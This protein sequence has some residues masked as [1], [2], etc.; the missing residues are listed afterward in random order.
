MQSPIFYVPSNKI[1]G[2]LIELPADESRHA[3]TV[4]RLK[5]NDPVV[6]VDGNGMTYRGE[7]I[8]EKQSKYASVRVTSTIRNSGEPMVR[9]T[10]AAGLS[11]G[12]KFDQVIQQGTEVGISRFVPLKTEKSYIKSSDLSN[13]LNR[14]EKVAVAAM[15]Q[16]RR[17]YLPD[18]AGIR[19]LPEYLKESMDEP[20]KL[21]FHPEIEQSIS[22]ESLRNSSVQRASL[23]IGPESGFSTAEVNQALSAGFKPVSLGTR[24][25]R[26]ETAGPVCAALVLQALG[27]YT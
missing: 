27:E 17:S 22:L 3:I 14:F 7:L 6:V 23:L 26:T 12:F 2:D 19:T 15:K 13:K 4:L 11:T 9:L 1:S 20:L 10:L 16:S 5:R 18:V 8:I 21:L 25:L 24:V